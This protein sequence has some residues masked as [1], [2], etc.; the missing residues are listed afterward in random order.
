VSSTKRLQTS[1]NDRKLVAVLMSKS[2]AINTTMTIHNQG[3]AEETVNMGAH[4]DTLKAGRHLTTPSLNKERNMGGGGGGG[5]V[6]A[7]P[8]VSMFHLRNYLTD[9]D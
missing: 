6:H 7:Y 3:R 8:S 2:H 9:F 4:T 1:L 5:R